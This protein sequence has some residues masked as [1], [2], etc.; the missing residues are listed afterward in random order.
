MANSMTPD[1]IASFVDKVLSNLASWPD[2]QRNPRFL[3]A[4]A[5]TRHYGGPEEGG[6]WYNWN[7]CLQTM[8]IPPCDDEDLE[9]VLTSVIERWCEE[10][11]DEYHY[12]DI[13]SVLGGSEVWYSLEY[14]AGEN[15]SNSRPRYE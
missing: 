11:G 7:E 6:W 12:G 4:Y 1:A 2:D 10:Y 13:Y 9:A 8:S 14:H 3:S 5:T 15:Q